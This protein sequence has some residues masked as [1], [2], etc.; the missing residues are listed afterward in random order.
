MSESILATSLTSESDNFASISSFYPIDR[1]SVGVLTV[2]IA[3]T[4][5]TKGISLFY[6]SDPLVNFQK[7]EKYDI[8][9]LNLNSLMIYNILS[10]WFSLF[11]IVL[12]FISQAVFNVEQT[13]PHL[14][15]VLHIF[16][17]QLQAVC[18]QF[19]AVCVP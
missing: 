9:L 1:T 2:T 14:K 4:K 6:S 8:Y 19:Q 5:Y 11:Y 16:C 3:R 10:Q 18:V 15:F 17:M 7:C 13:K 12:E